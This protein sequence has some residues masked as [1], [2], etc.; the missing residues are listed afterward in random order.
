MVERLAFLVVYV[1]DT[2][3][4]RLFDYHL[5]RIRR[6]TSVPFKIFAAANKLSPELRA[7]VA[8]QPEIE[9][10]ECVVPRDWGVRE[11]HSHC[12]SVLAAHAMEEDY[13]HF[14]TLHL[15]SFP[16]RD[17]WVKVLVEDDGERPVKCVVPNG[18]S[19]GLLWTREFYETYEPP[20][21]V[22]DEERVSERFA[23]FTAEY[24]DFDHV[25]TGL[26]YIYTAWKNGVEWR[27][28]RTDADRKIYDGMMFHLVAGT[29]RTRTEA[30]SIKKGPLI[31]ILWFVTRIFLR[32]VPREKRSAVRE[33]FVDKDEMG[34]DG[35]PRTK[36]EE[37]A[38][39]LRDPDDFVETHRRR[40][41]A[42]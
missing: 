11:E 8:G 10:V 33:F 34:R 5:S 4:K 18:Y 24:P 1:F 9:L 41:L 7:Y 36:R 23:A 29:W 40:Y 25:E 32:L 6:H 12:L 26:G 27:Q 2:D 14:M 31:A 37:L 3:S 42:G 35:T 30:L 17:G 22:P 19:A 13:S 20:M 39:L 21:L 15:D 28:I 16:I 38:S